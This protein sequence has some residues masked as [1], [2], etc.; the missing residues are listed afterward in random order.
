MLFGHEHV[1]R[2]LETGGGEG[3]DWEGT[4]VLILTTTGRKSGEQRS[5]PLIYQPRGDDYLVV[6][7]K[8]G[9]DE[10]PSWYVNLE[11][12]PEVTVQVKDDR[13]AAVARTATP[14][15]KPGMWSGLA[16]LRGVPAADQPGDPGRRARARVGEPR[17]GA[18]GPPAQEDVG[19]AASVP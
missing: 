8:G 19:Q 10:P 1:Q 5:T 18:G 4:T 15:E 2:Y 11:E 7:S 6:A 12:Q 9:A 17:C 16:G 13:F 3:H 14:D